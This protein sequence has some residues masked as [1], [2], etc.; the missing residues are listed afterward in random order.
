MKEIET[1]AANAAAPSAGGFQ[2]SDQPIGRADWAAAARADG[3]PASYGKDL[4]Y[5][6]A[7]DP[8][9]LFLYW[10]LNWTPLFAQAGLSPRE[11]QLR[12]YREDGSIERTQEINPFRGHCYVDVAAAGTGYYCELGCLEGDVWTS[13]VRSGTTATPAASMSEDVSEDFATLPIHLSFQRLIDIFQATKT[14]RAT[15]ANSMAELQEN[16][17]ALEEAVNGGDGTDP[18]LAALLESARRGDAPTAGQLAQWK[19][20]GARFGGASWGGASGGGFGG[21]SL[22]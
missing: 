11:V 17:Q 10:D 16:A 15:L 7:R 21:S 12:V 18:E 20:L 5:V 14:E 1:S 3:L 9:S 22:A 6:I 4:L 13:L 19:Q 8:K 2:V